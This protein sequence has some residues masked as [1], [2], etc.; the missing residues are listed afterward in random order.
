MSRR[1]PRACTIFTTVTLTVTR[2][3]TTVFT[4]TVSANLVTTRIALEDRRRPH[5]RPP[6]GSF[7]LHLQPLVSLKSQSAKMEIGE[8]EKHKRKR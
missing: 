7:L 5:L 4:R 8:I 2:S 6:T 3:T 1:A